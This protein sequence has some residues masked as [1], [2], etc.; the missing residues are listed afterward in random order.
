[1]FPKTSIDTN[2]LVCYFPRC[3]K[4]RRAVA[5]GFSV[6]VWGT[7]SRW[8]KSSLPETNGSWHPPA[9][10]FLFL[11]E[12]KFLLNKVWRKKFFLIFA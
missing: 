10:I 7:W 4:G 1:M 3:P 12:K 11:A 8:F 5:Q 2:K 9:P 6:Q